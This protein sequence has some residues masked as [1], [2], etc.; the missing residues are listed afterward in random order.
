MQPTIPT[1]NTARFLL[2]ALCATGCVSLAA[3]RATAQDKA[4]PPGQPGAAA[5]P[6]LQSAW[7]DL[8][9]DDQARIARAALIIGRSPTEGVA[10]L[11]Q[12]LRPVKADAKLL[13]RWLGELDSDDPAT[14]TLAQ[15]ELEYLGKYIK[16]DLKKALAAPASAEPRKRIQQILERIETAERQ[17]KPPMPQPGNPLKGRSVGVSNINGQIQIIVDGV[18]LDLTPRV[19]AP[20]G[21]PRAHVR[22]VRAIGI[23]EGIGTPEARHLLEAIAQGEAGALPTVEARAALDRLGKQ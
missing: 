16:D 1:R 20:A 8:G 21:P 2:M 9:G 18:P 10:F 3:A 14:R 11:K 13:Q 5:K 17:A 12:N 23:L 22:A 15:E 4:T 7:S 19:V 6:S